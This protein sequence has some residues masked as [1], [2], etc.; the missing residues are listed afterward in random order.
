MNN[1]QP[2]FNSDFAQHY[3]SF[4]RIAVPAYDQLFSMADSFFSLSKKPSPHLLVVGAGG[5]AELLYFSQTHPNWFLTGVDPSEQMLKIASYKIQQAGTENRVTLH[6][7]FLHELPTAPKFDMATCI[8]V[9]QFLPDDQAKL[10]LLTSVANR[11]EHGDPFILVSIYGNKQSIEFEKNFTAW[12]ERFRSHGINPEKS[13]DVQRILNMPLISEERIQEL[14]E[15][16]GFQNIVNFYSAYQVG[17][18]V[19]ELK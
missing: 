11:L 9:L 14:L 2:D 5:G 15:E 17:G 10:N 16:A 4:I 3:D 18:W 8:L 19:A 12:K 6:Q 13:E 1:S 7:G